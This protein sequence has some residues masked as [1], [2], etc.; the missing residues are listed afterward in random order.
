M[1]LSTTAGEILARAIEIAGDVR[2]PMFATCEHGLGF[3]ARCVL[4]EASCDLPHEDEDL[5]E[6]V[7][8]VRL[9]GDCGRSHATS[10]ELCATLRAATMKYEEEATAR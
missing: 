2:R 3:C 1:N 8:Y 7:R 10:D 6:A 4:A 5:I 9:V